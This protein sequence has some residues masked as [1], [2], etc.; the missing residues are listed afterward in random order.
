MSHDINRLLVK[1]GGSQTV[2]RGTLEFRQK[3]SVMSKFSPL[4]FTNDL[5]VHSDTSTSLCS[6]QPDF[7]GAG[8]KY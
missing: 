1:T 6:Y 4:A 8:S 3:V 5:V 7:E 2:S